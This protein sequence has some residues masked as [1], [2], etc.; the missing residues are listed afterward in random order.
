M[1][2]RTKKKST[3]TKA[4]DK[5]SSRKTGSRKTGSQRTESRKKKT[6][7]ASRRTQHADGKR[8]AAAKS[9]KSKTVVASVLNSEKLQE[10]YAT[11]LKC[12]ML[13]ERALPAD[14]QKGTDVSPSNRHEAAFVGAV[15]H[16]IP[17]DAIAAAQDGFLASF[18]QG[19]PLKSILQQA[20]QQLLSG[21]TAHHN[22]ADSF[23]NNIMARG[24]AL[25]T[26]IK[27]NPAAVLLFTGEDQAARAAHRE[28]LGMAAK[29]KL[30]VVCVMESRLA[31]SIPAGS[32]LAANSAADG[33][34][35]PQIVVDGNDVVGVFRVAQEAI[36][37]A[38]SGH[39]PSLIECVMPEPVPS[40][41]ANAANDPL[42]FM[43]QYLQHRNLWSDE[44]RQKIIQ[45]FTQELDAAIAA[46][47]SERNQQNRSDH[48]YSQARSAKLNPEPASA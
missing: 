48:G 25:A 16:A 18:I 39:G 19:A 28:Q 15:A 7:A 29:N 37:R 6:R 44:W 20:E 31:S 30:P 13:S 17:A 2:P 21:H 3:K 34:Y 4:A 46:M 35:F 5:T 32:P 33:S 43:Q 42:A 11:M 27:G 24:L 8:D 23:A 10:L 1:M 40:A 47:E 45:E 41:T 38:R 26:E 36:R 22:G 9:P 14:R 12:R